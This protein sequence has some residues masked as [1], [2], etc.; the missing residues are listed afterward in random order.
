LWDE[1]ISQYRE[2]LKL[3]PDDPAGHNNLGV[4][5]FQKGKLKEAVSEF[6]EALRL[7]PD[8]P[9][10]RRNLAAAQK[11]LNA[12]TAPATSGPYP[13]SPPPPGR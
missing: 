9:D 11:A 2:D 10:A 8:Y 12:S 7:K 1:A 5:F 3:N 4:A 6:Q 13:G